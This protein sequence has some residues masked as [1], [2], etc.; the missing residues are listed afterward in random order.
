MQ[1]SR[2]IGRTQRLYEDGWIALDGNEVRDAAGNLAPYSVVR[3]K[4]RGRC[5]LPL[6]REGCTYLVGQYRFALD[7]YSWEIPEGGGPLGVDF[8]ESAKRE[9]QEE[10]GLSARRWHKLLETDLSNVRVRRRPPFG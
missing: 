9:L 1:P 5:V 8:L 10:T 7:T 2:S 6:D 4:M 3:F